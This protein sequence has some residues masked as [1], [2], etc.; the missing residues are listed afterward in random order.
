MAKRVP[1]ESLAEAYQRL[2]DSGLRLHQQRSETA[3]HDGLI[4]ETTEISGARRVLLVLQGSTG[5]QIAGASLPAGEEASALLRAITPWLDEADAN[6]VSCLRHGPEGAATEDQ[7]SCLVAPLT[8]RGEL[9]GHLY[10]DIEGA[11]GRFGDIDRDLLSRLAG[12]A[13]VALANLRHAGGLEARVA[14]RT[15]DLRDALER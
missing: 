7:R 2:M 6:R 15:A 13:A 11:F 10:A 4:R 5:R 12:Q 14:T 1:S 3:L 9:L 8:A